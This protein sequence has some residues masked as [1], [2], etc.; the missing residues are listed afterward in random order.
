LSDDTSGPDAWN[1]HLD[2]PLTGP[3]LV[4]Q[5]AL[6]GL[7]L[8]DGNDVTLVPVS[9]IQEQPSNVVYGASKGGLLLLTQSPVVALVVA[10]AADG[11]RA[12]LVC[13][14]GV[15]TDLSANTVAGLGLVDFPLFS[16]MMDVLSTDT[17]PSSHA[18]EAIAYL[19]SDAVGPVAGASLVVDGGCCGGG[20][21]R[22]W[23]RQ[24]GE[25][26]GETRTAE[27]F[28][29]SL[30]PNLDEV[31]RA[32]RGGI[33]AASGPTTRPTSWLMAG[34]SSPE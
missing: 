24:A 34:G 19:A 25:S 33:A 23:S 21:L 29:E 32:Y 27:E 18:A 22:K 4:T 7:R 6:P 2:V 9:G 10:L 12:H 15:D 28:V 20:P 1:C 14:G 30:E 17:M 16:R 13:P 8:R 26:G 31:A 11:I 5:A 3:M